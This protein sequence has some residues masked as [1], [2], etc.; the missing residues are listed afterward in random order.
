MNCKM[1]WGE[2]YTSC[3]HGVYFR[4]EAEKE[5]AEGFIAEWEC[6]LYISF[7][8]VTESIESTVWVPCTMRELYTLLLLEA[9]NK[10]LM[11]IN[12]DWIYAGNMSELDEIS[13][14]VAR[15]IKIGDKETVRLTKNINRDMYRYNFKAELLSIIGLD[16]A[17]DKY[18]P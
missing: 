9:D 3:W 11:I 14:F 1:D 15:A 5:N 8:D 12:N 18:W 16:E 17:I 2:I 7:M 10:C 13:D 4:P 6:D